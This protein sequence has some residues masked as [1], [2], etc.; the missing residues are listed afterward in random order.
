MLPRRYK[1]PFPEGGKG[2]TGMPY[3]VVV[4]VQGPSWVDS[5][6]MRDQEQWTEHAAFINAAMYAG[7][8][9]LG[10]PLGDGPTHRALLVINSDSES[11][12][13]ARLMED[14]WIRSGILRIG[15]LEPWNLLVSNDK[16]D[17]VLAEITKPS[18]AT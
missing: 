15:S 10:G 12:V 1:A 4:N 6:S 11:A 3:F 5:R 17:P 2:E 8:V 7:F 14:P 13:R 16:L 9:L 18:L